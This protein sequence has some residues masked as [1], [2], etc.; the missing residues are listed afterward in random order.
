MR[1]TQGEHE[2][3]ILLPETRTEMKTVGRKRME[4]S[5]WRL[6]NTKIEAGRVEHER[7]TASFC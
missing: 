7:R 5:S 3:R 2:E 4:K 1:R 6:K